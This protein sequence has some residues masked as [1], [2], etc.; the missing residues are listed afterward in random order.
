M[1][2]LYIIYTWY[3]LWSAVAGTVTANAEMPDMEPL[4]CLMYLTG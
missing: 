2:H 4:R 3:L 1:V